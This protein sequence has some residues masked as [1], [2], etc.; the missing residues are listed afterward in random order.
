MH[1]RAKILLVE[2]L[3]LYNHL[4]LNPNRDAIAFNQ[5]VLD[6]IFFLDVGWEVAWPANPFEVLFLVGCEMLEQI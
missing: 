3:V 1:Q 2:K 5:H 4:M 6:Y